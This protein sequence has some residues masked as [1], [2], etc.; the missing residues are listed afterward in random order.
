MYWPAA[1]AALEDMVSR[2]AEMALDWATMFAEA[3][4]AAELSAD[5]MFVAARARALMPVR[6][7]R[8]SCMVEVENGL[9]LLMG[10]SPLGCDALK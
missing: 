5:R 8:V 1:P 7:K 9:M 3:S 2:A 4:E 6:V 10:L